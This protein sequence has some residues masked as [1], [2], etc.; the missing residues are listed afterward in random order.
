MS[1]QAS[2]VVTPEE[3]VFNIAMSSTRLPSLTPKNSHGNL[4]NGYRVK[5]AV[6][7]ACII[8]VHSSGSFLNQLNV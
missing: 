6:K 8:Y 4:L 7:A 1:F 3:H 2:V 5:S